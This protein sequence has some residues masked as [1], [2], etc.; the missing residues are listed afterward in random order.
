M[1]DIQKSIQIVMHCQFINGV[2]SATLKPGN[3]RDEALKSLDSLKKYALVGAIIEDAQT[4]EADL[5]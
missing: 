4:T 2:L 3:T 5:T 1:P